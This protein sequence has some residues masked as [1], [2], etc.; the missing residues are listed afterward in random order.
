MSKVICSSAIDGAIAW[1]AK[2]EGKLDEAVAAKASPAPSG[3][4][5]RPIS[6]R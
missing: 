6:C 3:S 2:A 1:V 4:R 5:T